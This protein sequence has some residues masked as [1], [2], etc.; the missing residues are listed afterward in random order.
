MEPPRAKAKR[1][2]TEHLAKTQKDTK[3]TDSTRRDGEDGHRQTPVSFLGRLPMLPVSKQACNR[4]L[5][6]IIKGLKTYTHVF[7]S[8][9]SF[10]IY[11]LFTDYT[12]IN[13]DISTNAWSLSVTLPGSTSTEMVHVHQL[14]CAH[15]HKAIK[16]PCGQWDKDDQISTRSP[17]KGHQQFTAQ[18][19]T[20]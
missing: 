12:V 17:T 2:A 6:N 8:L 20:C 3:E 18:H 1:K 7:W 10:P 11:G 16:R 14:T 19:V 5:L 15:S 4:I 13:Y 9:S